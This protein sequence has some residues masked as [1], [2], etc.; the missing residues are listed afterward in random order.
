MRAIQAAVKEGSQ[1]YLRR[2]YSTVSVV[3]LVI[4]LILYLAMNWKVALGFLIGAIASALAG[5][6]GMMTAVDTN[7]RTA[8]AARSASSCAAWRSLPIPTNAT[9]REPSR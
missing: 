2:Q 3:A 8:E 9:A 4:A 6:L 7:A 1:S 5:Y